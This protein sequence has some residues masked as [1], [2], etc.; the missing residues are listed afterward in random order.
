[1]DEEE[2]EQV[3]HN[4]EQSYLCLKKDHDDVV[5]EKEALKGDLVI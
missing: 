5:G 3:L 2:Q 1:M 4:L